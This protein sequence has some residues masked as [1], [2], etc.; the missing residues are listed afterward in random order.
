MEEK[1]DKITDRVITAL[2]VFLLVLG[3]INVGICIYILT[4]RTGFE[5]K[6]YRGHT[7]LFYNGDPVEHSVNCKKCFEK[8]D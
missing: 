4:K 3:L 6:T 1:K 7:Y 5:D 8:F 2:F